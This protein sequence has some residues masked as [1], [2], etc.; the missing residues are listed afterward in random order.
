MITVNTKLGKFIISKNTTL[1]E[2][3][4]M[5]K[6]D[7]LYPVTLG[8]VNNNLRELSYLLKE[9]S[10]IEWIDITDPDGRRTYMRSLTFLFIRALEEILPSAATKIQHSL[11]NGFFC[12]VNYDKKIDIQDVHKIE[13]R[14]R[15]FIDS[16]EK[17]IRFDVSKEEAIEIYKKQNREGKADLLKY[18]KASSVHL[19]RSGWLEDYFYGYMVPSTAILHTFSLKMYNGGIVLLGPDVKEPNKVSQFIHQPKLFKIYKEA[20]TWAKIIN[21]PNTA[22]LNELVENQKYPEIIRLAEAYHEK[23][24]CEIADMI[25][26]DAEKGKIILIAGPSSSGLWLM[27]FHLCHFQ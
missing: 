12:E 25:K 11:S 17:I 13:N 4:K 16:N 26:K 3:L 10:Y 20:K 14:M 24:I 1:E 27:G 9:D 2:V 19:Y 5:E 22:S 18:K 6:I 21:L 7:F 23:K 15:E 8:L